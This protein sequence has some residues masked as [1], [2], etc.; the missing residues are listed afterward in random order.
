MVDEAKISKTE[1]LRIIQES[2]DHYI[3][4]REDCKPEEDR[5]YYSNQTC[6][7]ALEDLKKRILMM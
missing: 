6:I 5:R 4:M 2:E 7:I 1:V 3:A